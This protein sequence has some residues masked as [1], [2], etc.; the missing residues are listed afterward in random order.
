MLGYKAAKHSETRVLITLE[1]PDDAKTNLNR[2]SIVNKETATY[3]ADKVK[4]LKIEDADGNTYTSAKSFMNNAPL[5]YT[6]GETVT[7]AGYDEDPEKNGAGIYFCLNRQVAEYYHLIKLQN[8]TITNYH[9]NGRKSYETP[10]VDGVHHGDFSAWYE[11]GELA[12]KHT[13]VNGLLEGWDTYWDKN[14][15]VTGKTHYLN[16]HPDGLQE[17]WYKKNPK[18][19]MS[20][21]PYKNGVI[22]G[23]LLQWDEDGTLVRKAV[24]ENGVFM[25]D[26]RYEGYENYDDEE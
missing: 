13:Y 3:R 22:H 8:G 12:M 14:G 18:Q 2:P 16:G 5:T 19:K 1:I 26:E 21:T 24:V 10:F 17:F 25:K 6:V 23:T 11:T 7:S 4:V 15:N 9:T 20:E